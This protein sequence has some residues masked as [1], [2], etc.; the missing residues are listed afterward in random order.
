MKITEKDWKTMFEW[1]CLGLGVALGLCVVCAIFPPAP[2]QEYPYKLEKQKDYSAFHVDTTVF[3]MAA[4]DQMI[5]V[6]EDNG[7]NA[8][9]IVF[10]KN[11]KPVSQIKLDP[12]VI[13]PPEK[14]EE[15]K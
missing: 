13:K 15:K 5:T 6:L 3:P 2:L 4:I 10:V 8:E 12:M 7:V 9:A 11:R 14:E 1:A